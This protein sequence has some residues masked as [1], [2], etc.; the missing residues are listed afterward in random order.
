MVQQTILSLSLLALL[1]LAGCATHM[2]A[3]GSP[4]WKA[5]AWTS[6]DLDGKAEA[7]DFDPHSNVTLGIGARAWPPAAK[8]GVEVKADA[9]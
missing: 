4:S 1:V 8:V 3:Q 5:N 9:K 2:Q 7:P 6:I